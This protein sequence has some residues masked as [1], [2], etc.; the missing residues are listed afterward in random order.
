[1]DGPARCQAT[2]QQGDPCSAAHYRDGWCRWHHPDLGEARKAWAAKGGRNGSHTARAKKKLAGDLRDLAGVKSLLLEAM[3]ATRTG[4]MEPAVLSA[5][6]T[7][8]RAVVAV[9]GVADF[10]TQ[11]AAMRRELADLTERGA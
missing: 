1:M 5:L 7:A 8:A 9:A 2:N 3:D 6:A 11:L 4:A 10:E